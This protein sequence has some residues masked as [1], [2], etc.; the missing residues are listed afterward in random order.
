MSLRPPHP[1]MPPYTLKETYLHPSELKFQ[2][3]RPSKPKIRDI[4]PP[5][6]KYHAE[7][8]RRP[9]TTMATSTTTDSHDTT[10][11][12]LFS[13]PTAS[14]ATQWQHNRIEIANGMD[15]TDARSQRNKQSSRRT[16]NDNLQL[17][18]MMPTA[19]S[20]NPSHTGHNHDSQCQIPGGRLKQ[21]NIT[22]QKVTPTPNIAHA[23]TT[24]PY[25]TKTSE[26]VTL[27]LPYPQSNHYSNT[28]INQTTTV[29]TVS[30]TPA[31]HQHTHHC[32]L[33]EATRPTNP[34]TT[35]IAFA[36]YRQSIHISETS[37]HIER[38]I[39]QQNSPS[40]SEISP[41]RM[42]Q[43]TALMEHALEIPCGRP[44]TTN[45][46]LP[47]HD[48]PNRSDQPPPLSP[49]YT[50]VHHNTSHSFTTTENE[51]FHHPP[52]QQQHH[53]STLPIPWQHFED[54]FWVMQKQIQAQHLI[55]EAKIQHFF[56]LLEQ[57]HDNSSQNVSSPPERNKTID[58]IYSRP[59]IFKYFFAVY[60]SPTIPETLWYHR[61]RRSNSQNAPT[62][63]STSYSTH[64]RQPPDDENST[65]LPL[66]L[67]VP[68]PILVL[69]TAPTKPPFY[70][71]N[72]SQGE[73]SLPLTGPMISYC[74]PWP[75]PHRMSWNS[76]NVDPNLRRPQHRSYTTQHE[77][78]QYYRRHSTQYGVDLTTSTTADNSYIGLAPPA[79]T[80]DEKNLLRPP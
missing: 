26:K 73:R 12:T 21:A 30:T 71:D 34:P 55:L 3:E 20:T 56:A 63:A 57:R 54:D 2:V 27:Q 22:L 15:G 68:R 78:T 37:T 23:E 7:P 79:P 9:T 46:S 48:T 45:G 51:T 18:A 44:D 59:A 64:D 69:P 47:S 40:N 14:V 52:Q 33:H 42:Q 70:D 16:R 35:T 49:H 1:T 58:A 10:L 74:P 61:I 39:R 53:M 43:A 29:T 5:G 66:I 72:S 19:Q 76:T 8:T 50:W 67:S 25:Y 77:A 75:P 38:P 36:A 6:T 80:A 31:H 24:T 62:S 32:T 28:P 65:A 60:C 4:T 41:Q 17:P 11:P 13:P